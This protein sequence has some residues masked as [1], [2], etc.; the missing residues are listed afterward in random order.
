NVNTEAW[1]S[2]NLKESIEQLCQAARGAARA[3]ARTDA[4]RIDAGLEAIAQELE[5]RKAFIQEENARD[6]EAAERKGTAKSTVD[7]LRLNDKAFAQMV[8]GIRQVISLPSPLG[9]ILSERIRPNGLV[10][11]KK[12]V[13]LGVIGFIY[14]SR[15]NVTIDAAV[16][17]LKAGNATI[18]RGGSDAF[19]SNIALAAAIREGLHR[20]GLPEAAIQLIETTEREAVPVLCR[21]SEYVDL[22]IP[23]GGE[24][25]IRTVM[26]HARMPVIKHYHG[27]CHIYV[28]T[29]AD[30]DLAERI[31]INA[32]CQKPGVCNSAETLLIDEAAAPTFV[33]RIVKALREHGVE[34]RG[35][36]RTVELGG[37]DIVPTTEAD[38]TTEYL[39]L[40]ISVRIVQNLEEAVAHMDR[41]GSHHSDAIV[42]KDE[43]AAN[44]FFELA[45]SSALYWNAS[46]RFTDGFEFGFGAEIGI[47]T[48]KI[49]ARGP[50]GLEELTSYKY[51]VTGSGQI[52]S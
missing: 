15:P 51:V 16:L 46:T 48:D 33:P 3:L 7:R 50:M 35:D 41:Y 34:V 25:L 27:V 10:I 17:C 32:K 40:I 22:L 43:A 31:V 5:H 36:G 21:Q 13:P 30:F 45:D 26:E 2:V 52:R 9:A 14:E 24:S 49:H 18:L 19:R 28:H 11:R 12:R 20:A 38:W 1:T 47:S 8:L 6:V 44:R 39:D 23:R 37:T 4:A 42:T 29:E